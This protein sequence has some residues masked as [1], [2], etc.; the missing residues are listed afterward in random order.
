MKIDLKLQRIKLNYE[1]FVVVI[2]Q[3]SIVE[4]QEYIVHKS[5]S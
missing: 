2:C 1:E 5:G 3:V 4:R